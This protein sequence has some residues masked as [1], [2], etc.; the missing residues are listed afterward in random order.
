[1]TL[2]PRHCLTR[3]VHSHDV[4]ANFILKGVIDDWRAL[5][6]EMHNRGMYV[7]LDNTLGT[8]GDLLEW[9]G[10]ENVSAPFKYGE[11]DVAWKSTRQ[12]LDFAV[13]NEHTTE[14]NYPRM[15]GADGY[16]LSNE[17][18]LDAMKL[19]C[20]DSEFDQVSSLL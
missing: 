10:S 12:Y 13:S 18:E 17:T 16:P 15:W 9:V 11:Y 4:S 2:I 3:V 19:P 8:M 1:V 6:T 14:C 7:I 5:I 20:K